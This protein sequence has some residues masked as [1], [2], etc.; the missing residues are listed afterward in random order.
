MLPW[1]LV[2]NTTHVELYMHVCV[3]LKD[4][5]N[6]N[7]N[8]RF[9]LIEH[10]P[11]INHDSTLQTVVTLIFG[12]VDSLLP[13]TNCLLGLSYMAIGWV[14]YQ[15]LSSNIFHLGRTCLPRITLAYIRKLLPSLTWPDPFSSCQ[16]CV[17]K[18]GLA[19]RD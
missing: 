19:T 13:I 1:S 15:N 6:R 10:S 14:F 12:H 8:S 4:W 16:K 2:I 9:T 18:K 7:H 3:F 5:H 11:L 17:K